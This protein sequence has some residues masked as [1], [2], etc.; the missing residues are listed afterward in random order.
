MVIS[1]YLMFV[2]SKMKER[3]TLRVFNRI[4]SPEIVMKNKL[5]ALVV[6]KFKF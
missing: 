4:Q 6:W 3:Y 2:T 1:N 5:A